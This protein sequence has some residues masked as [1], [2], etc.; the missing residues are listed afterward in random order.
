MIISYFQGL[1]IEPL[2]LPSHPFHEVSAEV[3]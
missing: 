2:P 1:T 3:H